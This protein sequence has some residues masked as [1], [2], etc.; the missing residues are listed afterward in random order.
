MRGGVFFLPSA[1]RYLFSA[2]LTG[3]AGKTVVKAAKKRSGP[4]LLKQP[5]NK[6]RRKACARP[7]AASLAEAQRLRRVGMTT[8]A[9]TV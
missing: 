8:N 3:R 2:G 1:Q 4:R 5:K 6:T 9:K 7:P